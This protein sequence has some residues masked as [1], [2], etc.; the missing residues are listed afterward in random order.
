MNSK[1]K[2]THHKAW[3]TFIVAHAQLIE[4]I[5]REVV[6]QGHLSM[7]WYDVLLALDKS[8]EQRLR[9]SELSDAVV[10]SRSGLTRFV[11]RLEAAGLLRREAVPG[12]RRGS[13]AV[14]TEEGE[15]ALRASWPAYS[16]AIAD[17]FARH[18]SDSE[19][20]QMTELLSRMLEVPA[21]HSRGKAKRKGEKEPV[22]GKNRKP[23]KK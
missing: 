22:A 13:Y 6:G 3:G 7:D 10:L 19:A 17:Y 23:P 12:D 8:P 14:L 18:L 1:L 4:R 2:D 20:E 9:M 16:K 11:D 5:N 15:A 21:D